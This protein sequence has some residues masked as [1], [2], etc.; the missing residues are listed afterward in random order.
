MALVISAQAGIQE[1]SAVIPAQAGIQS[2]DFRTG[3]RYSRMRGNNG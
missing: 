1:S 2:V 3:I